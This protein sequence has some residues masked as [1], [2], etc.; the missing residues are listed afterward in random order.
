MKKNIFLL[1]SCRVRN[2]YTHLNEEDIKYN[3]INYDKDMIGRTYTLNETYELLKSII[4]SK[5]NICS[6]EYRNMQELFKRNINAI[7]VKN[8]DIFVIEISSIKYYTHLN[9]NM[10]SNIVF[11]P[12]H[13][14]RS[15]SKYELNKLS[16]QEMD[17]YFNKIIALL[18]NKKILFVCHLKSDIIPNRILIKNNLIKN[19]QK[20]NNDNI[21]FVDPTELLNTDNIDKY[22]TD[23]YHYNTL[24]YGLICNKFLDLFDKIVI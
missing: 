19:I 10:D 24:G 14:R 5:K 2:I 15:L 12:N 7:N 8:I 17:Y 4:T 21:L 22:L 3:L 16:E 13:G 23:D 18:D 11:S 6:H 20:C 9:E 1:G